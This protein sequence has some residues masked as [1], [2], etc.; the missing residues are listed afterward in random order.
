MKTIPPVSNVYVYNKDDQLTFIVYPTLL[1]YDTCEL[2]NKT[3]GR[4]MEVAD[5]KHV[6]GTVHYFNVSN[7]ADIWTECS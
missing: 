4:R 6:R 3:R 5:R 1:Q 2:I 7:A